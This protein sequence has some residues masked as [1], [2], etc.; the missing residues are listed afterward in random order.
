MRLVKK[1]V[2][3]ITESLKSHISLGD[4]SNNY[5]DKG[6]GVLKTKLSHWVV[7][8]KFVSK[9]KVCYKGLLQLRRTSNT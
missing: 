2:K 1:R 9:R 5:E 4:L 7:N 3:N 8:V 6:V